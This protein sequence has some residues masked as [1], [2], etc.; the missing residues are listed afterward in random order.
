MLFATAVYAAPAIIISPDTCSM[1][2]GDGGFL[3]TDNIKI[4][5]TNNGQGNHFNLKCHAFGVPNSTGGVVKYDY[6]NTGELCISST[7]G[8]STD[9]W[10]EVVSKEGN[11]TLTCKYHFK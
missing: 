11:A 1:A 7:I 6:F 3:T 2:D 5:N 9:D 4:V 8:Q 10:Q